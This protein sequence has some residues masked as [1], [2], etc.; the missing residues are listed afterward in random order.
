[1][2]KLVRVGALLLT[3]GLGVGGFSYFSANKQKP[4]IPDRKSG[5]PI[6]DTAKAV[7]KRRKRRK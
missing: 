6:K 2:S 1:M 7:I 5:A 3:S 4:S